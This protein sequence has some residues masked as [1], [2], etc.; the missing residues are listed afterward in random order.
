[1]QRHTAPRAL[2]HWRATNQSWLQQHPHRNLEKYRFTH[3]EHSRRNLNSFN[4]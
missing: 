2:G 4:Q 3:L 1:M